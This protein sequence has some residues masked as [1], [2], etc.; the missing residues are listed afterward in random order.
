MKVWFLALSSILLWSGKGL[1][2]AEVVVLL[3]GLA[4]S[5]ESMEK[6]ETT[7]EDNGYKTLNID[8]PS[9]TYCIEKLSNQIRS[10]IL[11]EVP[12]GATIHFV[13]HSMGGILV[14]QIQKVDPLANIGRVVMLGPPNGGS[15]VVDEFADLFVFQWINGPAGK[16][17][18]TGTD[19]FISGLGPVDFELGVI[20]GSQSI[21]IILSAVIPG[22]DDGKVSIESA[23]V[24]GMS[25]FHVVH[26]SHPF[27]MRHPRVIEKAVQF[28]SEGKF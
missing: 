20:A 21:N 18:G 5:S 22:L 1:W 26:A 2:G 23:K 8:Y 24:E 9:T 6:L 17:L 27:I 15:E 25:E 12:E 14:R 4:R 11:A 13:T 28:V 7:F 19:E 3:H 10:R 16:Q